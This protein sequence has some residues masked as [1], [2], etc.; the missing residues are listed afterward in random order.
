M[1]NANNI[2]IKEYSSP[3]GSFH[4]H[5]AV[6]HEGQAFLISPESHRLFEVLYLISG[7]LEYA[8]EGEHYAVGEGDIILISPNEI[9]SLK[10][11]SET[12]YERVVV[13]FDIQ[14]LGGILSEERI[15]LHDLLFNNFQRYRVIKKEVAEENR[16]KDLFFA[17][18]NNEEPKE[19]AQLAFISNLIRLIIALDKLLVEENASFWNATTVNPTIKNIIEYINTHIDEP[20]RLDDIAKHA[21][22]SKSTI[23]HKFKED[24]NISINRYITVKKIHRAQELIQSGM[25]AQQ[26]SVTIGYENYNSFFYNYK[27]IIGVSPSNGKSLKP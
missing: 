12:S 6:S 4:F 10:I 27:K 22:V 14:A 18:V 9:H 26:A 20:L 21:F 23:C 17:I 3:T 25:S 19:Y 2:V 15:P 11:G 8:V 16:L 1:N 13:M 24:M 7:D 5:H